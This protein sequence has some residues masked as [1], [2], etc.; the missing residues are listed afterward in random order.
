M[1]GRGELEFYLVSFR[2]VEAAR[3]SLL[4]VYVER[5]LRCADEMRGVR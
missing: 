3:N 4:P 5:D 2:I 1:G